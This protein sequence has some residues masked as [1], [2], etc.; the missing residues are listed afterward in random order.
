[1]SALRVQIDYNQIR[2]YVTGMTEHQVAPAMSDS[3]MENLRE[4]ASG[5]RKLEWLVPGN[6]LITKARIEHQR[7]LEVAT[8][9]ITLCKQKEY[10]V[11]RLLVS[12]LDELLTEIGTLEQAIPGSINSASH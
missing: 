2:D 1:M 7:L 11:A 4:A 6:S 3:S 10:D 8:L 5:L 12:K 9:I